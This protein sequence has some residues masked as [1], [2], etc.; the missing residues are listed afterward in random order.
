MSMGDG[1]NTARNLQIMSDLV[2]MR[3]ALKTNKLFLS[4]QTAKKNTFTRFG[5]SKQK[6]APSPV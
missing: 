4:T 5:Q 1:E 6:P 2:T 3:F